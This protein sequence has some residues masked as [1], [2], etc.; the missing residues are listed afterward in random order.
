VRKL[1]ELLFYEFHVT[2]PLQALYWLYWLHWRMRSPFYTGRRPS[3]QA[4]VSFVARGAAK[5]RDHDI[6]E[7]ALDTSGA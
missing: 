5:G 4:T 7:M 1:G 6:P 3:G 2:K